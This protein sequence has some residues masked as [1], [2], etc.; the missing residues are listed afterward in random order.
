MQAVL[1]YG[2]M[3]G[4]SATYQLNIAFDGWLPLL[5][6][7]D[8]KATILMEVKVAGLEGTPTHLKAVSEI[9]AFSMT[10]DGNQL[11]FTA[12]NVQRFFPKTTVA[13][14]PN[15][16]VIESDAPKLKLPVRMPGLDSQRFPEITYLPLELPKSRIEDGSVYEF[17]RKFNDF[18]VRY[19]VTQDSSEAGIVQ[20]KINLAQTGIR[21][22]GAD[23]SDVPPEIPE[24]TQFNFTVEGDGT[25]SFD[26]SSKLFTRVDLVAKQVE[27][28]ESD[29]QV[30][31]LTTT[32]TL[33]RKQSE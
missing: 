20:F 16:R 28:R 24:A 1:V 29:K 6:G 30:R 18:P 14:E 11:P 3:A 8:T 9:L 21:F 5:G 13:F 33:R 4:A 19:R 10:V 22:E 15:G 26:Q 32:F 25:A 17:E 12:S 31:R 27:I 23:G 7:R 2:L